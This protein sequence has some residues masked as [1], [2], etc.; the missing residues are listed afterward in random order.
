MIP[1]DSKEES[2][3]IATVSQHQLYSEIVLSVEV[4]IAAPPSQNTVHQSE[5]SNHTKQN[6]DDHACYFDSKPG[7]LGKSMETIS[8]WT[9]LVGWNYNSACGERFFFFRISQV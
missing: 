1:R 9:R 8:R 7:T 6:C 4:D 2:N 3:W 5:Q